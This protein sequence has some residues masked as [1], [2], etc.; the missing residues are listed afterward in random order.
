[1]T[2]HQRWNVEA[3]AVE[4]HLRVM[5]N[6]GTS[7]IGNEKDPCLLGHQQD[8]LC[9]RAAECEAATARRSAGTHPLGVKDKHVAAK[10]VPK[11]A[12]DH[13]EES[14]VNDRKLRDSPRRPISITNGAQE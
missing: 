4:L 6:L 12:L 5:A 9:A 2:A 11:M 13:L 3:A 8:P 7:A 10:V 14:S 1:M